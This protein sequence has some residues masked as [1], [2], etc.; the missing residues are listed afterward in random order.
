MELLELMKQRHSIRKYLAQPIEEEKR[1]VLDAMAA[2]L[3]EESGMNIQLI[4]DEPKCFSS[5]F[6]S[7]YGAF[8]GCSNY[9]CL[10]G[11]KSDPELD[12]KSGYYGEQLVLKA[13][14]LGLNTCW[15]ALTHGKTTARVGRD[16]KQTIVIALGYGAEQ[17][18][19]HKSKALSTVCSAKGEAPE[20]FKAGMEAVLLAPTAVN[21]QKFLFDLQGETV[22]AKS[23]GGI[24]SKI[25]LGIVKYHF[26]AVSGHK[27]K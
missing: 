11:S 5:M 16:E 21:Q 26:E 15:V 7:H 12:E 6:I 8:S 1:A 4:Y 23:R 19:P 3:N 14:E 20:W 24:C 10:V 22:T 27:V 13:Q 18:R 17:G 2:Q 9:I 25:D